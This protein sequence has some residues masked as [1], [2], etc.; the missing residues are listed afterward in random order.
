MLDGFC[1][2]SAESGRERNLV[3]L[4]HTCNAVSQI[5]T[6]QLKPINQDHITSQRKRKM[7]VSDVGNGCTAARIES[8][9]RAA[10]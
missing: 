6:T 1:F 2:A 4:E 7:H 3:R 9:Y 8:A 5:K 10:Q